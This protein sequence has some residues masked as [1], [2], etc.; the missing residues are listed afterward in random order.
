MDC[1]AVLK[2]TN[3]DGVYDSDPKTNADAQRFDALSFDKV[4]AD[5]LG[6]MDA[7]AVALCRDND[8]PI[9]VFSIREQHNLATILSGN[10]TATIVQNEGK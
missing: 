1:D 2:G 8:I 3:V 10:G 4:L 9:V 5:N 6:V 7:S